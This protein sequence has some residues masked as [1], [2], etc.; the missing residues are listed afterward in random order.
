MITKTRAGLFYL[1]W[2][3]R[4]HFVCLCLIDIATLAVVLPHFCCLYCINC[5]ALHNIPAFADYIIYHLQVVLSEMN[6]GHH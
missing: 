6:S 3:L 4:S 5:M 2:M 1:M